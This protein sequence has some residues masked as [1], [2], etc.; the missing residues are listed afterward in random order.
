[1][2]ERLPL[3]HDAQIPARLEPEHFE[4][5]VH[6]V[7]VL[8]GQ[9]EA[10]LDLVARAKRLHDRRQLD[11][12]GTC[13]GDH[14]HPRLPLL[15]AHARSS[16]LRS[17]RAAR[18]SLRCSA[19]SSDCC[20][21][22]SSAMKPKPTSRNPSTR[23]RITRYSSGRKPN[24]GIQ[25]PMRSTMV[26]SPTRMPSAAITRPLAPNRMSGLREKKRKNATD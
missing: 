13:P 12:F 17:S 1:V 24:G 7:R 23:S 9:C 6:Q 15:S 8:A 10:S 21:A 25:W 22:T 14:E 26:M 20:C 2:V 3:T 11:R 18:D 16:S 5:L 19:S 4:N